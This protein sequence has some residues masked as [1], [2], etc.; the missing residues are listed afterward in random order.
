MDYKFSEIEKKWQKYWVEN[1][2]YKVKE[3]SSKKKFYVLDMFPYPSGAGLHVGHP[4]GYIAS[5][6]FAR[7]KRQQGFN[8][9]HPMGYDSYGL[10]AEQYA[11][12]TGQHPAVTTAKNIARYR[13]QL[14]K[15]G[16]C[17]DWSREVRTCEP[18]Y[19]KWTQWAFI[20]MFNSYYDNDANKA[21]PIEELIAKFEKN[22]NA[23]VNAANNC[24]V[25]FSASDW[26]SY[27]EKE[28]EQI[29]LT[30]RIAY[31]AD[32]KVN[33]C[34][35]LGCVLA[36]DEISEGVSVRGGYPVEQRVMRQWSLRVSAYAQRLLDGL[37]KIDWSDA[38]KETQ[39]NWIGRSEG[40]EMD[41]AVKGQDL[42]LKIFTTR[43]D[44]IHGVTFMVL[45]PESEYV[46]KVTT[47]DQKAA[48]DDYLAQVKRRT[49]R[50]R[51]SD[52]RVSGVFSG[53]YAINPITEK[54]IPIYISD[55]VL[56]GYGTGAI[57]AVPAHDSRDYAFA[58]H[59]NLPIIPLI[60]GADVSEES[61]D[62]KEGIMMNSG[63]LNG[64]TVK[65]A[66]K[67]AKKY[68]KEK[69]IGEVK[70]NYRLRDAIFS[71]QRYWGEPFPV[72]YKDGMPHMLDESKLP[73]ELPE[74]SDFKPTE[75]G[76]PPLGHAENW[77]T[78]EGYPYELNTM[79]GFAGSSAYYLRYMDPTNDKALVSKE[80][81][82]Y[83][84]SVDLYVGGTEHATGHL[85]YSRFWNKFLFDLGIVCEDEPFRKL[86][87]QGMI[88]GRSNFVYRIKDTNT[89]VSLGLKKDYDVTPIHVDV[90]IVNND[91]LD[92]EAFK[93]WRPEFETA[94]FILEDGKYV[95][96]WAVEKMSKS[97]FNV[98][99]PDDIVDKYGADTLRLYEMFLG[100]IEQSK[101]WDTKGIDGVNRFLKKFWG[102]FFTGDNFDVV[103]AEPTAEE[104]KSI[105]KLIKKVTGDVETFSYN[106]SIA[107]FM[108]CANELTSL[109]CKNAEV[110]TKFVTVL[111]PFAPH[112][113]EELYH[114]L[115]NT[116]SVCDA[117]WP[118]YDEK[119]LVESS[120]KYPISFNGKVRFTLELP[121]D[122]DKADVE[123]T[124]LANDQTI[125]LLD[126]KP[127]KKVIVVPGKI[128]NIVF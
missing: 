60:E 70:V 6:I 18:N 46:A 66:L 32:T 14:D 69:G 82:Q 47:A 74:V 63:F 72:Y 26:N 10:P 76:E 109:K 8:V 88:Q 24:T 65:E 12:Q 84:K 127:T 19:Y 51:I 116:G 123:K 21:L 62:A 119:F 94:E 85:I 93:A 120:V 77:C 30:Y 25:K 57:M 33:F 61:F 122:M 23:S 101:P 100:P 22:G 36:N 53:S 7:Y 86:I 96:G 49:E 38:L 92:I 98:V 2:T 27:S 31:L 118:S 106:T 35:A 105:H 103:K 87:N 64:L 67:T 9:L 16:F 107:A 5:D 52:R 110:L 34:P 29:L 83:W 48:V 99:N 39:K 102:M 97:M 112:I 117:Q 95:C 59:F 124:A 58:K 71:R 56:A 44:T 91:I 121:A 81:N 75:S 50:E 11:I 42:K 3:D 114:L 15:I 128:V 113:C 111:A 4:L 17:F 125:K 1:A 79:P 126:G 68:I 40:A 78:P 43:C 90:N 37:D 115:G 89:F 104:Q 73:L 54:E 41:F 13:E 80:A 55:Y 20:K 108:I 28:K 45:A